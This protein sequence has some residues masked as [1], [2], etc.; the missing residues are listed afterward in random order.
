MYGSSAASPE[1][2]RL[3]FAQLLRGHFVFKIKKNFLI[4]YYEPNKDHKL[5]FP[6]ISLLA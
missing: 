1:V 4:L 6:F 2:F 3:L 5:N